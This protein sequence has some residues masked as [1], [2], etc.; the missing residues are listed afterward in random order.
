MGNLNF[1]QFPGAT[2][3]H[4]L[5]QTINAQNYHFRD[6]RS[7]TQ[8]I[9]SCHS[10]SFPDFRC[11]HKRTPSAHFSGQK[12][13]FGLIPKSEAKFLNFRAI[14]F[15]RNMSYRSEELMGSE[16]LTHASSSSFS[17]MYIWVSQFMMTWVQTVFIFIMDQLFGL[18]RRF[19][20]F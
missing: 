17:R 20:I 6:P 7:R 9:G 16:S 8:Y 11:T 1:L 14:Y 15:L 12:S 2:R 4:P 5:W 18:F 10:T 19:L 13:M 3:P